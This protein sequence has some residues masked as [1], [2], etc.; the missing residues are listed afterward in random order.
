[1]K[2]FT[3]LIFL[4]FLTCNSIAQVDSGKYRIERV[5]L[6]TRYIRT[7]K[8]YK[9]LKKLLFIMPINSPQWNFIPSIFPI[10]AF[11]ARISSKFGYRFHPVDGDIS[12]HAAIDIPCRL[13][14]NIYATAS[15]L[16]VKSVNGNTGLGNHIMINHI[17]GFLTVYGHLSKT[18]VQSGD[19][20]NKGQ[21]IGLAGSTG[22]STGVHIHYGI[23]KDRINIDPYPF[24]FVGRYAIRTGFK[25]KRPMNF[26]PVQ[27]AK[28]K[29][30]SRGAGLTKSHKDT[31]VI[32]ERKHNRFLEDVY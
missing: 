7:A 8:S 20:V 23:K 31:L 32:K 28:E 30:Y 29:N 11:D 21:L 15:G 6:E 22:K 18:L 12:F 1:M 26:Y 5:S 25:K 14:E 13:G 3:I 19:Y 10:K 27:I 16:V 2:L 24:C 17:N 4:L 9:Q